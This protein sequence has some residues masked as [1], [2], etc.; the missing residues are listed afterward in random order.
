MSTRRYAGMFKDN[1][2][3]II[4]HYNLENGINSKNPIK[5]YIESR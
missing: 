2:E 3:A 1:L 4:Y 5:D